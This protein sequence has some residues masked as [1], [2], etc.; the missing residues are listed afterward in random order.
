MYILF[1]VFV[2]K[3]SINFSYIVSNFTFTVGLYLPAINCIP[4]GGW[5]V[6]IEM[7]FYL[8]LPILIKYINSLNKAIL[9]LFVF[10]IISMLD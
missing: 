3:N 2:R 8:T 5:S 4:P 10:I 9:F 1:E 7:L 6:G